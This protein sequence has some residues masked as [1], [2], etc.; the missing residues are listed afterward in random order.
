MT[1]IIFIIII[2]MKIIVKELVG[3]NHVYVF[4]ETMRPLFM[5]IIQKRK[6]RW[7]IKKIIK[8]H[9]IMGLQFVNEINF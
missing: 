2:P 6:T 4:D 1:S 7:Y 3:I 5:D 9:N 8:T